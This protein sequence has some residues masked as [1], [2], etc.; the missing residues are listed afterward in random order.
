MILIAFAGAMLA[1]QTDGCVL[2]PK[3]STADAV[4]ATDD[5]WYINNEPIELDGRKYVKYGLPRVLSRGDVGMLRSYK[6]AVLY[7]D[8]A[9]KQNEV[10]YVLTDL[11][12]CEFQPYQLEVK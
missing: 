3:G 7:Y 6:G 1:S 11:A 4:R 12:G 9:G 8:I 10:L 2:I 5:G